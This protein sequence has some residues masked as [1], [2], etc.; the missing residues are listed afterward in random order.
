[1]LLK[2]IYDTPEGWVRKTNDRQPDG[3]LVD[4][5]KPEGACLNPPPLA[6]VGLINTGT[7]P[8]QNFSKGLI[9]RAGTEGWAKIDGDRLILNVVPEPLVYAIL[10][11]PGCYCCH[12]GELLAAGGEVARQHI[13]EHHPDEASPDRENPAGYRITDAYECRLDAGQHARFKAVPGRP[14]VAHRKAEG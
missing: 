4:P 5:A 6:Y 2:R 10:R 3:K 1:M 13:A 7:T 9:E 8:E 14:L 11:R 12:C